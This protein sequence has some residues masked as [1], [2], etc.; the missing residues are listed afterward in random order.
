META[1]AY[2]RVSTDRQ[3][4]GTSLDT[5]TKRVNQHI[6]AKNY[7]LE[8][9]FAEEG[10]S[11]KTDARPVLQEMLAYCKKNRGRIQ[12]L[13]FPKIDRFARYTEDYHFLKSFLRKLGVRVESTDEHFDDSPAGRYMENVLAATAQFDNDLRSERCKGGMREAALRGRWVF[14]CSPVGFRN[15]R[16]DGRATIEPDPKTAPLIAQAFARLASRR[17]TPETVRAWLGTK[18]VALSRSRFYEVLRSKTY[19]GVIES[20]DLNVQAVPPFIPIVSDAVFF[21]AQQALQVK[22]YPQVID[23]NNAHFPLRGTIRCSCGKFMTASWSHGRSKK[24]A[25]YRCKLC[26]RANYQRKVVER[27][28][29]SLLSCVKTNYGLNR[30]VREQVEAAWENEKATSTTRIGAIQREILKVKDLQKAIAIKNAEGV[31]PDD[32]AR[33]QIQ[34]LGLKISTKQI[35][36][37]DLNTG[38][39]DVNEVLDFADSFLSSLSTYWRDSDLQTKKHVQKFFFPVGATTILEPSRTAKM[40]AFAGSS[41]LQFQRVSATVDCA[42]GTPHRGTGK[43]QERSV[44]TDFT[45]LLRRLYAEFGPNSSKL[46]SEPSACNER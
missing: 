17:F 9:L 32:V 37:D 4:Q 18:G 20:F 7:T 3:V 8:R 40:R 36:L 44:L 27:S 43:Q 33:E 11:A 35:Q 12:V 21:R 42:V 23:R 15:T 19:I 5:Q 30:E 28:F 46:D 45:I 38:Y 29:Q 16:F 31:V 1:I 39:D 24:Y 13:I 34:E 41:A 2:I 25:Y 6:A 10:D 22:S 26:P 14:G